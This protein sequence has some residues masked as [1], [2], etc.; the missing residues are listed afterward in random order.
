MLELEFELLLELA[1]LLELELTE[2]LEL[3]LVSSVEMIESGPLCICTFVESVK[4]ITV[5]IISTP[6][7]LSVKMAS[8][9]ASLSSST[10]TVVALPARAV[11]YS[12]AVTPRFRIWRV[13]E[14]RLEPA[15]PR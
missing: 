13:R 12:N 11:L 7:R 3:W 2:L 10:S 14:S 1:E 4:C 9:S 15:G 6:S 5:G 8:Y